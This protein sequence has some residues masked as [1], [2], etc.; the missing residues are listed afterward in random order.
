MKNKKIIS[1]GFLY[2]TPSF[3]SGAGSVLNIFGD[4]FE[5]NTSDEA[6]EI[7]IQSDFDNV[8]EDIKK[9]MNKLKTQ[10]NLAICK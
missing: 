2:A 4:Y 8:G 5:Y 10:N 1:T 3:L 9:A 6:D 7:A